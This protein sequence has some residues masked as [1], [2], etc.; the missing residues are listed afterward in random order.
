MLFF[1]RDYA[2]TNKTIIEMAHSYKSYQSLLSIVGGDYEIAKRKGGSYGQ[3][4]QHT[5]VE[6]S[7]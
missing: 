5:G 3:S 4:Q 2:C 7:T 6:S 1:V